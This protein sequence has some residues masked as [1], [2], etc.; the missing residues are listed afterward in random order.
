MDIES[1]NNLKRESPDEIYDFTK[2]N[3]VYRTDIPL[4]EY[5]VQEGD[6]MRIDLIFQNMYNLEPNEVGEALANVDIV[7]FIN[8]IDNPLNI[9]KGQVLLYPPFDRF[10][11]FRRTDESIEEDR[12]SVREKLIVPNKNT[13]KDSSRKNYLENDFSLPPVVLRKPRS[14]VRLDGSKISVGGL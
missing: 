2:P 8:N 6:D 3:L 12:N 9:V 13:K 10:S 1:L 11:E 5:T 14:P 4:Q 7:L